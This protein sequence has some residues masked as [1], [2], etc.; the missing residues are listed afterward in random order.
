MSFPMAMTMD[1]AKS[2]PQMDMFTMASSR[3]SS[4]TRIVIARPDLSTLPRC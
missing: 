2:R 4:C 1:G 3:P